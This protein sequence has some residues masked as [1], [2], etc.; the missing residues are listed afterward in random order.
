MAVLAYSPAFLLRSTGS[1]AATIRRSVIVAAGSAD[2]AT[3]QA[4]F[5]RD[6]LPTESVCSATLTDASGALMGPEQYGSEPG[7]KLHREDQA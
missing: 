5:Y 1:H 3:E 7:L 4:W 2:E 6:G